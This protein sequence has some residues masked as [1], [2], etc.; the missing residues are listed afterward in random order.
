MVRALRDRHHVRVPAGGGMG[1]GVGTASDSAAGAHCRSRN[2]DRT[3]LH[4]AAG[5]GPRDRGIESSASQ[6]R[7]PA[8]R[9][10]A[11]CLRNRP[12]CVGSALVAPVTSMTSVT[13]DDVRPSVEA[14]VEAIAA[15]LRASRAERDRLVR[16]RAALHGRDA[17][18]P[19]STRRPPFSAFSSRS[20][21]ARWSDTPM[22]DRIAPARRTPVPLRAQS[23]F[24]LT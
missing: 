1:P 21:A 8:Q 13:V 9:A 10:H 18:S 24:E 14:D 7:S 5:D 3:T 15:I 6:H 16:D 19:G 20:G 23:M 11:H 2:R 17:Q 4:T 22:R 12:L